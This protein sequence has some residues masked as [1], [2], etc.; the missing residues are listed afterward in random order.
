MDTFFSALTPTI[1]LGLLGCVVAIAAF[2]PY[3]RDTVR[4]TTRPNRAT[5][6]IYTV[7]GCLGTASAYQAGARWTLLVAATYAVLSLVVALLAIRRGEGGWS[8]LDQGCIATAALSLVLWQI[9]GNPLL[10]VVLNSLADIA[11]SVPTMIKAWRQPSSEN[12]LSWTL[13]LVANSFAL[14]ATV[15]W[16]FGE[17]LYPGVLWA[18]SLVIAGGCW[19]ARR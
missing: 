17:A 14:A 7:V 3:I 15:E 11:G 8:R 4:G 16:T 5:W 9:T 18:C 10:A 13:F 12:R 19:L 1:A 2:V 6:W